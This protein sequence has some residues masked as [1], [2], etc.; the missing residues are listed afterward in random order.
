M[1]KIK[2]KHPD[3]GHVIFTEP[4]LRQLEILE[5]FNLINEMVKDV[6]ND[7]DLGRV[8]R[9]KLKSFNEKKSKTRI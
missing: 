4:T 7:S 8:V 9:K 1:V 6:P 3:Y 5:T 2:V